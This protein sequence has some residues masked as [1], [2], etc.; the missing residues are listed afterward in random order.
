MDDFIVAFLI[1]LV[2]AAIIVTLIIAFPVNP[3]TYKSNASVRIEHKHDRMSGGV[4]AG[5][6]LDLNS[7][8]IKPGF[9]VGPV[10]L[11]S[12]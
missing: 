11:I 8:T 4:G 6:G 5:F 2:A 1:Y 12:F 9:G 3:D 10:N 7:G